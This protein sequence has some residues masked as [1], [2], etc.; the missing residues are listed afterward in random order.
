MANKEMTV[1][2][3][4]YQIVG[5]TAL[6]LWGGGEATIPM[7]PVKLV[8]TTYPTQEQIR[9][10]INDNGFGAECMEGAVIRIDA[11]YEH[12]A[13]DYGEAQFINLAG[14]SDKHVLQLLSIGHPD[15]QVDIWELDDDTLAKGDMA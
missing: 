5:L 6:A 1:R 9:E 3:I 12:G 14:Y 11:L 13:K 4:G 2:L 15:S 7:A 10:S 8:Q